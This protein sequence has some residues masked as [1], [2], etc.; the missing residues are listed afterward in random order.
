MFKSEFNNQTTLY[1]AQGGY[2][3]IS[4][5]SFITDRRA[6]S[7]AKRTIKFYQNYLKAFL[8]YCDGLAITH[9][10]EISADFLRRYLLSLEGKHNPGGVHA[11]FRTLRVFFRWLESEEVMDPNWK[12]PISKV[13]APKVGEDPIEPIHLED[14]EALIKTCIND[15]NTGVRDKSI[16]LCLLDTGVRAQEFC[17]IDTND[18]DFA[19]GSILIRKGKGRKP[20]TVFVGKKARRALRGYLRL[21]QDQC[22]ALFVS[23]CGERLTY[24][25]LRQI[26]ERR[27]KRAGLEK[28][29]SL[30]D[31]RRAFAINMLRNGV[32]IFALQRL[33][34]HSDLSVLRRYLAQTEGDLQ[35]AHL[36]G[37]PV[38][39]SL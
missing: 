38:D 1:F 21:R 23:V 30:H 13:R 29:P 8:Q 6:A 32:N 19:T 4:V 3:S 2:L 35:S 11:A 9:V 31:F 5:E 14:I 18:V 7:L 17:N 22:P 37:S 36:L 15:N 28:E 34:G 39:K 27:T 24:D 25:G 16:F 33:M 12:N 10:Q 26:L 20:R